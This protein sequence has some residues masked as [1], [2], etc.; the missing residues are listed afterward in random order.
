VNTLS[1][2]SWHPPNHTGWKH[3][4]THGSVSMGHVP[5][6][7]GH[8]YQRLLQKARLRSV[9]FFLLAVQIFSIVRKKNNLALPL[10]IEC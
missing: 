2:T 8:P 3:V 10:T 4:S 6:D 5:R 7:P 1:Y 9:P